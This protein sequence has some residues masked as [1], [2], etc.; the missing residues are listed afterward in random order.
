MRNPFDHRA[1]DRD[2]FR[3]SVLGCP[4]SVRLAIVIFVLV[5]LWGAIAWAVALP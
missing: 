2:P 3:H 4:A 1:A 5:G